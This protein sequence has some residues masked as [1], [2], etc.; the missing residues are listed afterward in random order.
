MGARR[1]NPVIVPIYAGAGP[2]MPTARNAFHAGFA[3]LDKKQKKTHFHG[4]FEITAL[5]EGPA[6]LYLGSRI[7]PLHPGDCVFLSSLFPHYLSPVSARPVVPV[8]GAYA[9]FGIH[10]LMSLPIG[11][12]IRDGLL[13]RFGRRPD[14]GH[15][16]RNHKGLSDS[17]EKA[18]RL[19]SRPVSPDNL[20]HSWSC[21]VE[22][23]AHLLKVVQA[24]PTEPSPQNA[25]AVIRAA[26][27]IRF[28]FT[29]PLSLEEIAAHA[30]LSR[31][32]LVRLFSRLLGC[33]PIAYRN[34]LR[35]EKAK[36][37][38][39]STDS[40]IETIAAECGFGSL[41]QF[42]EVFKKNA[43]MRPR[44]LRFVSGSTR[45]A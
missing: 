12:E 4:G 43:G 6:E 8:R 33:P 7:I 39:A 22:S 3:R 13:R 20:V 29:R 15:V 24:G 21:I 37:L 1:K 30:C 23:L 32:H 34:L 11:G 16:L 38:L 18:A 9:H 14:E 26:E 31:F 25:E 35:V 17:I 36:A 28:H 45:R 10:A 41:S 44:E 19:L 5:L 2:A 42:N 40:P 27:F